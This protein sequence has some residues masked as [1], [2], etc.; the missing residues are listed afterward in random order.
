MPKSLLAQIPETVIQ[1][2]GDNSHYNVSKS[3]NLDRPKYHNHFAP[4]TDD[5][6]IGHFHCIDII[7][8]LEDSDVIVGHFQ[9]VQVTHLSAQWGRFWFYSIIRIRSRISGLGAAEYSNIFME[10][11]PIETRCMEYLTKKIVQKKYSLF[12][13]VRAKPTTQPPSIQ[14]SLRLC[15]QGRLADCV[16]LSAGLEAWRA[17]LARIQQDTTETAQCCHVRKSEFFKQTLGFLLIGFE[18]AYFL[19]IFPKFSHCRG[20]IAKIIA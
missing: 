8:Y 9:G 6:V 12:Q 16:R 20:K 4:V 15:E 13:N 1:T 5:A 14:F 7:G 2:T 18:L 10:L 17:L 11:Q 19:I 3:E